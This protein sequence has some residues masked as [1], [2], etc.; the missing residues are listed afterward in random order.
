MNGSVQITVLEH[1]SRLVNWP[2]GPDNDYPEWLRQRIW[3]SLYG[4]KEW[5]MIGFVCFQR[6][7][8]P[9]GAT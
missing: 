4:Q 6:R 8:M 9:A 7:N 5:R 2:H 3:A 1:D